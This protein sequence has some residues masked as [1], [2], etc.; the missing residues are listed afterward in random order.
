M[1]RSSGFDS[2]GAPSGTASLALL[3]G[4]LIL[5]AAPSA[6]A[7]PIYFDYPGVPEHS[8]HV[9]WSAPGPDGK[10]FHQHHYHKSPD[11]PP[12][13]RE[14][15]ILGHDIAHELSGQR[16]EPH[17]DAYSH[18]VN[19]TYRVFGRVRPN[20]G[21]AP[22]SQEF[23]SHGF[24]ITDDLNTPEYKLV[25]PDDPGLKPDPDDPAPFLGPKCTLPDGACLWDS[26]GMGFDPRNLVRDAF[27]TWSTIDNDDPAHLILGLRFREETGADDPAEIKVEF[28]DHV[29]S[30]GRAVAAAW[31]TGTRT[32]RFARYR[33]QAAQEP[34]KWYLGA[35]AANIGLNDL[36]FFTVALHEVGH[37]VGLDHQSD[38]D[39]VMYT[40]AGEFNAIRVDNGTFRSLSNDDKLGALDLYTI[41]CAQGPAPR[42]SADELPASCAVVSAPPAA[43]LLC[44]GLCALALIRRRRS[45]GSG[46]VAGQVPA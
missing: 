6:R 40:S 42:G 43:L 37:I 25:G 27:K 35:N 22:G 10:L 15:A 12:G 9:T 16:K 38:A 21:F 14:D 17:Y 36:D 31:N 33:D 13:R 29:E 41:P 5:C 11:P 23:F 39:D 3:S 20:G 4:W 44:V 24:I 1:L 28:V 8:G 32:L 34:I 26:K 46:L 7:D 2:N 19:E 30:D 18:W 45:R